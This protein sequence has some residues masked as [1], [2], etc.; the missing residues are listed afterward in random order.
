M[1]YNFHKLAIAIPLTLLSTALKASLFDPVGWVTSQIEPASKGIYVSF[2]EDKQQLLT[3]LKEE[4]AELDKTEA[5][6]EEFNQAELEKIAQHIAQTKE[7]IKDGQ[8]PDFFNKKLSVLNEHYQALIDIQLSRKQMILS[9][10]QQIKLLEEYLRDPDF[11]N[12][13]LDLKGIYA[14]EHLQAINQKIAD[15][16]DIIAHV[17]EQKNNSNADLES[18]KRVAE[19]L[20]KDV[21]AKERELKDVGTRSESFEDRGLRGENSEVRNLTIKQQAGLLDQTLKLLIVKRQLAD[22]KIQELKRKIGFLETKLFIEKAKRKVLEQQ[23]VSIKEGLRVEESDVIAQRDDL[24]Q[25]RREHLKVKDELYRDRKNVELDRDHR[26]AS[27]GKWAKQLEITI[28][29]VHDLDDIVV[30]PRDAHGYF[31]L[32]A[33]LHTK[34]EVLLLAKRIELFDAQ[35][36]LEDAKFDREQLLENSVETWHKLTTRRF[37]SEEEVEEEIRTYQE[38]DKQAERDITIFSEKRT[39]A[40]NFLNLQ[41]KVF[42]NLKQQAHRIE[43]HQHLFKEQQDEYFRSLELLV[44]AQRH[45]SVQ[46]DLNQKIIEFYSTIIQ[47]RTTIRHHVALI[48]NELQSIGLRPPQAI[49]WQGMRNIIAD[50]DMLRGELFHLAVSYAK[51]LASAVSFKKIKVLGFGGVLWLIF[52]ILLVILAFFMGKALLPFLQ[53]LLSNV[54]HDAKGLYRA[55]HLGACLTNFVLHHYRLLF[56]WLTWYVLL[57]VDVIPDIFPRIIFYLCSIPIVLYLGTGF[58]NFFMAYNQAHEE[59]FIGSSVS[60]RIAPTVRI[61][62][63]ATVIIFYFRQAFVLASYSRS[64]V[65]AILLAVYSIIVRVMLISLI[66]KEDILALIPDQKPGWQWL[67]EHVERHYS[68]VY[69]L[70]LGLI[71]LSEPHIGFGKQVS[72]VLW[73]SFGTVLLVRGL[74][75]AYQF[76][77][78]ASTVLFFVGD[79]EYMRERFSHAKSMYG[80]FV[81]AVFVLCSFVVMMLG[82]KVWGYSISVADI[83]DLL[84]KELLSV[85]EGTL[86]Q[87]AITPLFLLYSCLFLIGSFFAASVINRFVLRNIFELLVIDPGIQHTVSAIVRYL[88][89]M[90]FI[91]YGFNRIGMK[92]IAFYLFMSLLVALAWSLR[93]FANDFVSYFIILVQR[94]FKIGDYVKIDEKT[95]GV[96]RKI[97][98]RSVIIREKNSTVVLVP[99]SKVVGGRIIN[100]NYTRTFVAFP[101]ILLGVTFTADPY[102][103]KSLIARVLDANVHVLKNP[104]PVIRLEDFGSNGYVFLIRGFVSSDQV[105]HLYDIASDVR[106]AVVKVLK[107]RDMEITAPTTLYKELVD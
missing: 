34:E 63:W 62:L 56:W 14:L 38:Y 54:R 20:A 51:Q 67:R 77:R 5:Q 100:W 49:S 98:P 41:T 101:D 48:L 24:E 37:R 64:E 73:G 96:V 91:L 105:S 83:R 104:R 80:M 45:T 69:A 19:Q 79:A 16:D 32:S 76:I 10:D 107:E 53:T 1:K 46:V 36:N 9:L 87:L 23:H 40:N 70:L 61:I 3:K 25:K 2:G 12:I 65:P 57:R 8:A 44:G 68:T 35:I 18:R 50:F 106:C 39:T 97:T 93:D 90:L 60:Q 26:Y 95:S 58:L 33:L 4:K 47:S 84:D 15:Q 82:A 74:L 89:V 43:K 55:S 17:D 21:K 27:M 11:K 66:H 52:R 81:I 71:I 85:G 72:Y 6:A 29:D 94:P 22:H 88:V 92:S 13:T 103:V 30:E 59:L 102:E 31:A 86:N 28:S 42:E 99:N 75:L 7:R 78:Q